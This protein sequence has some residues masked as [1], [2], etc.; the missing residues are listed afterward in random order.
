[1][2][3][4]VDLARYKNGLKKCL[5]AIVHPQGGVSN[6]PGT[7]YLFT[8]PQSTEYPV[9]PPRLIPFQFNTEQSYML[10]FI[11]NYF[12]PLK[13]GQLITQAN[14]NDL[15]VWHPYQWHELKELD[16]AQSGDM[17]FI[18]CGN[19]PP[20]AVKRYAEDNWVCE[21]LAFVDG[22]WA[23]LRPEDIGIILTVDG[24]DGLV[25]VTASQD[26][27]TPAMVGSYI[28]IGFADPLDP[29]DI[30]WGYGE[31]T[32]YVDA[33]TVY[34]RVED[35]LGYDLV[36]NPEFDDGLDG[37][38][39]ISNGG[40]ATAHT[41]AG[42]NWVTLMGNYA[43]IQQQIDYF[44]PKVRYR[45]DFYGESIM[46]TYPMR[47]NIQTTAGKKDL[48]N[49]DDTI[50]TFYVEFVQG[51][52]S[53]E[54]TAPKAEKDLYVV[55][56][57]PWG[58]S[59]FVGAISNLHITRADLSTTDWRLPAWMPGIDFLEAYPEHITFYE[60]RLVLA[61]TANFPQT[62]WMSRTGNFFDF[63]FFSP[64]ADDDAIIYSLAS[65]KIDE[66]QWLVSSTDLVVGTY[67]AIWAMKAGSG[68]DAITPT[69]ISAKIQTADGCEALEALLI[70]AR[71]VYVQRGAKSIRDL[72]Y[73]FENDRLQGED[74]TVLAKHIFED[75][76]II[77]WTYQGLDHQI[78]WCAMSTGELFA[79]TYFP[80]QEVIGWHRHYFNI[81]AVHDVCVLPTTVED[82]LYMA[83]WRFNTVDDNVFANYF[84]ERMKPRLTVH[85]HA[86]DH[87]IENIDRLYNEGFAD[88]IFTP[89]TPPYDYWFLDAAIGH[90]STTPTDTIT[91][92]DHLEGWTVNAL[93]DGA[94]IRD[95]VVANG[96]VVL[97]RASKRV[98]V[99]LPYQ[100]EIV[101]LPL[102]VGDEQGT[103]QG[104]RQ[105]VNRVT[106]KV[107][108]TRTGYV[109]CGEY[110]AEPDEIRIRDVHDGQDPVALRTGE[111]SILTP[112]GWSN[113]PVIRISF[114]D[115][116]P[117]TVLAVI[118]EVHIGDR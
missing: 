77:S 99:G 98:I 54:F 61:N 73:N 67:N 64:G 35:P 45:V 88:T 4:R 59:G 34:M 41:I 48:L 117:I 115:P 30:S 33:R 75:R 101:T 81:A 25:K 113:E 46:D 13:D 31:I 86:E 74:L 58:E 32:Q 18:V 106:M 56:D 89:E 111:V 91:G 8:V 39:N 40:T 28:R 27:F 12:A 80:E 57:G 9:A 105:V 104:R 78:I 47:I 42:D 76:R 60:Q 20:Q 44:S 36:Y 96:Q 84:I 15:W 29:S 53:F 22:P 82:E 79:L 70:N 109:D 107:E 7:E 38:T 17:L 95:L 52:Y 51:Q 87:R 92:L 69:S 93:A 3:G 103:G 90:M 83:V 11:Q 55:I 10:V 16:Y 65:R 68:S 1:M 14:G 100:G 71:L 62:I 63:G 114:A 19:H 110:G 118:P 21:E 6:R 37:W 24:V 2:Y 112:S 49:P 50:T 94:V 97:P 43:G 85:V 116:V 72:T 66:I 102:D 26:L 5:N 108:R 23:P